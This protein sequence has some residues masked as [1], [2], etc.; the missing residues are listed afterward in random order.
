MNRRV[1]IRS[2]GFLGDTDTDIVR[3]REPFK[4][5]KLEELLEDSFGDDG[6]G[7]VNVVERLRV[8]GRS[9]RQG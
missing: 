6:D 8:T 1:V 7:E 5:P 2:T 4:L 9:V 3:A